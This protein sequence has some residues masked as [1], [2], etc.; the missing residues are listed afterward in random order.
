MT[1]SAK[2]RLF[3]S[4]V[5]KQAE[6][7]GKGFRE[8]LGDVVNGVEVFMSGSDIDK[9]TRWNDVLTENLHESSCAIVCLTPE[10]L[11]HIWVAFEAGAISRAAGGPEQAKA[12][13]WTYL[14]GLEAKELQLTPFSSYQATGATKE[15]TFRLIESINE[16]SADQVKA[17]ALKRKFDK[18]FWPAFSEVL[19]SANGQDADVKAAG[20]EETDLLPEILLTVR[21][22]QQDIKN[23]VSREGSASVGDFRQSSSDNLTSI[24][25]ALRAIGAVGAYD[26]KTL[27]SRKAAE[28]WGNVNASKP[29]GGVLARAAGRRYKPLKG[30]VDLP[31]SNSNEPATKESAPTSRAAP[32]AEI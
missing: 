27:Q 6:T 10:S 9:G 12:R 22:I 25:G 2:L 15:E 7:L 23:L 26:P 18:A 17:E 16:L 28:A 20:P 30:S 8:Y 13:I 3:I 14:H 5:G 29:P 4:W 11:R 19:E 31:G 1:D 24:E 32:K 21:S